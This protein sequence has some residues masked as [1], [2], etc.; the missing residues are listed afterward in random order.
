MPQLSYKDRRQYTAELLEAAFFGAFLTA[1]GV[2]KE[3]QSLTRAELCKRMGREKTGLSKL[4][5]GPRNWQLRTIADLSEALDLRLEFALVDR[6]H[7]GRLFT[8]T[9]IEYKNVMSSTYG[10]HLFSS[11]GLDS[12]SPKAG[13]NFDPPNQSLAFCQTTLISQH[14]LGPMQEFK[15]MVEAPQTEASSTEVRKSTMIAV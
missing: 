12:A 4:L 6:L 10:Q 3:E 1:I 2:R 11:Q 8:Q 9:G 7:P 15:P 14:S 5:S 13:M